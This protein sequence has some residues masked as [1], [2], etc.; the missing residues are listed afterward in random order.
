MAKKAYIGEIQEQKYVSGENKKKLFPTTIEDAVKVKKQDGTYTTLKEALYSKWGDALTIKLLDDE[1]IPTYYMFTFSVGKNMGP[2]DDNKALLRQML[3]C[4]NSE[5]VAL[6]AQH[7]ET[8]DIDLTKIPLTIASV[9]DRVNKS[10][11]LKTLFLNKIV[12][13]NQNIPTLTVVDEDGKEYSSGDTIYFTKY[14]GKLWLS[15]K[16]LDSSYIQDLVEIAS[17]PDLHRTHFLQASSDIP[18]TTFTELEFCDVISGTSDMYV[19][20][21]RIPNDWQEMTTNSVS[22]FVDKLIEGNVYFEIMPYDYT[23]NNPVAE[24]QYKTQER[25]GRMYINDYVRKYN[26]TTHTE[27]LSYM[28]SGFLPCWFNIVFL[29]TA[30]EPEFHLN[31]PNPVTITKKTGWV[32]NLYL[33]GAF[34]EDNKVL[35]LNTSNSAFLFKKASDSAYVLPSQIEISK[36]EITNGITLN[37]RPADFR[38]DNYYVPSVIGSNPGTYTESIG[39][40]YDDDTS[41]QTIVNIS[42]IATAE[43][44]PSVPSNPFV[45]NSEVVSG[46]DYI[47]Y[48]LIKVEDNCERLRLMSWSATGKIQIGGYNLY[49]RLID[50]YIPG[51]T[52]LNS[53]IAEIE[54]QGDPTLYT[55]ISVGG[56]CYTNTIKYVLFKAVIRPID[57]DN[58]SFDAY[59]ELMDETNTKYIEI[60]L[61]K[62]DTTPVDPNT[63]SGDEGRTVVLQMDTDKEYVIVDRLNPASSHVANILT[64]QDLANYMTIPNGA[65]SGMITLDDAS[66]VQYMKRLNEIPDYAFYG[67]TEMTTIVLPEGIKRIGREAFAGCE[68]LTEIVIPDSVTKID[69]KAF[70]GCYSLTKIV[71]GEGVSAINNIGLENSDDL[72]TIVLKH[73]RFET[74]DDTPN[75]AMGVD[76]AERME[77]HLPNRIAFSTAIQGEGSS[78]VTFYVPT[79]L[80]EVYPELNWGGFFPNATWSDLEDLSE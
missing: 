34:A 44:F 53:V 54:N 37:I 7:D 48:Y 76:L 40:V 3:V 71:F 62:Q 26:Q 75:V 31:T 42:C 66:F 6:C 8:V 9:E 28:S 5:F 2:I 18:D 59:I 10:E 46:K 38:N 20:P 29:R 50:N 12:L 14:P 61:H 30:V 23:Y 11:Y 68:S 32:N 65:F 63:H 15:A 52:T 70:A 21:L 78:N 69:T 16:N 80:L 49:Y 17:T 45:D 73:L 24:Q 19:N 64:R 67:C 36:E 4:S 13:H 56:R 77:L 41:N 33:K 25:R 35:T 22:V 51:E 60:K 57:I 58:P 27:E 55:E 72:N 79:E 47:F 1:N 74:I 39:I 43:D